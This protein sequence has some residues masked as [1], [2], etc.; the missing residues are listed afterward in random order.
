MTWTYNCSLNYPIATKFIYSDLSFILLGEISER[1]SK[2]SLE[3]YSKELMVQMG[4]P[5][6]SF[7]PDLDSLLHR[8]APA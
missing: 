7:L 6:S 3:D 2:K 4:M 8:I 1:V 5:N